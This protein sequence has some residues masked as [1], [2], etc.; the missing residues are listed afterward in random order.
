[1]FCV[2]AAGHMPLAAA[3]ALA[4]GVIVLVVLL[5]VWGV[6]GLLGLRG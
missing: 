1:M 2:I 4:W 3:H 6:L 5:V